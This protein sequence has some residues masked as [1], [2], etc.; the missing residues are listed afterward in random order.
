[1]V[2][3]THGLHYGTML[4]LLGGTEENGENI[5]EASSLS[6]HFLQIKLEIDTKL[7]IYLF[8]V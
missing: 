5:T 7:N 3:R 6:Y 8:V 1:M 4:P 2:K